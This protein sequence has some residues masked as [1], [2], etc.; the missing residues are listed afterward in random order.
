[1]SGTEAD[2]AF[3]F[4]IGCFPTVAMIVS[5]AILTNVEVSAQTEACFQNFAAGLILAAVA[6]ELFPILSDASLEDSTLG[7]TIGFFVGLCTVYGLEV[8]IGRLEEL[9]DGKDEYE[10]VADGVVSLMH[11]ASRQKSYPK[12][13]SP[14]DMLEDGDV[15]LTQYG[16]LTDDQNWE[17]APVERASM[18]IARPAHRI[19]IK[20]HLEELVAC[21]KMMELK[22]EE[23]LEKGTELTTRQTED[24]AERIDEE[25]H[26][27]QYKLDHCRRLL[28]GSEAD[29]ANAH[30]T[31]GSKWVTEERKIFMKKRLVKLRYTVEHLVEHINEPVIDKGVLTEMHEHMDMMDNQI[32]VF[33]K[34]I[35]SAAAKWNRVKSLPE[36]SEGDKLPLNL[37]LPVTIDCFVDG[38]LIG[39]SVA[40][41]PKAG[42]VL[43][44]ANCF[45][46]SFLGMAYASR[47]VKCTGTSALKRGI[48]LYGPPLLMFFAAGV[49]AALAGAVKHI[50]MLFIA[51]VAFGVVALL[52]LVCNELLIEARNAQGEDEKWWISLCI[53]AGVYV[54]LLADRIM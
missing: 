4:L 36:T 27:L 40:I 25:I 18:A 13:A 37:V 6:S 38:F 1:M 26:T 5:E 51:F 30:F 31:T 9:S 50:P 44:F 24:I 32:E 15:E 43:A 35:E 20:E 19:H 3:G 46:M 2:V 21:V 29:T 10:G 54:V 52:F 45:E 42:I 11:G 16:T 12:G 8:I 7:I 22:S 17:E 28:Q 39:V 53:F 48:A 41:S 34:T 47:L 23:L 14:A 33:H 49:G